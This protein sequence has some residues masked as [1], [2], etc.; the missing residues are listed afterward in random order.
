MKKILL[1]AV[2]TLMV[3]VFTLILLTSMSGCIS[4]TDTV[5]SNDIGWSI[6][7]SPVT[8]RYYE[9]STMYPNSRAGMMAMSEVTEQE[10]LDYHI[11][12]GANQ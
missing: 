5:S 8:G 12:K 11:A 9:I 2:F 10:Y 4:K 7:K 6:I 1:V 3:A